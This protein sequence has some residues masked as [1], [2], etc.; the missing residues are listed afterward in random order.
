MKFWNTST[1]TLRAI[2]STQATLLNKENISLQFTR[3]FFSCYLN[4]LAFSSSFFAWCLNWRILLEESNLLQTVHLQA[5]RKR[6]GCLQTWRY[7]NEPDGLEHGWDIA[8]QISPFHCAR[9]PHRL[10]QILHAVFR[11]R[12]VHS[13]LKVNW[14]LSLLKKWCRAGTLDGERF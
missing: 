8:V 13:S 14:V 4:F 10:H 9:D 2:S 3:T 6:P 12:S 7:I 5:K 1:D 11:S